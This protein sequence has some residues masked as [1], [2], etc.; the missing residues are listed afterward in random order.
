MISKKR[1]YEDCLF[2]VL[3]NYY[4]N[5]EFTIKDIK[6]LFK[7]DFKGEFNKIFKDIFE[8]DFNIPL[9]II[10]TNVNNLIKWGYIKCINHNNTYINFK[11][12]DTPITTK[13]FLIEELPQSI[14]SKIIS[15]VNDE[16]YSF[17]NPKIIEYVQ[18]C[19]YKMKQMDRKM[20]IKQ[21]KQK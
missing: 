1:Y 17:S 19:K 21:L 14:T 8:D 13:L 6:L 10:R 4:N 18:N 5:K 11:N 15:S 2:I 16:E 20:K 7:D 3:N 9:K 12:G